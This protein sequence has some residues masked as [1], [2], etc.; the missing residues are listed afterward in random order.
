VGID[1]GVLELSSDEAVTA[2][3]ILSE[4]RNLVGRGAEVIVLGCGAMAKMAH[5]VAE[6]L[7]VPVLEPLAVA[8][9][10]ADLVGRARPWRK[11]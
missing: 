8:L 4:A 1:I 6:R 5:A 7:D 2:E 9:N 10:L 3:A 11:R